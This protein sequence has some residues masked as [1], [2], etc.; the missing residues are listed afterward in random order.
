MPCKISSHCSER[1][2]V[3]VAGFYSENHKSLMMQKKQKNKMKY[4]ENTWC[5]F[6]LRWESLGDWTEEIEEIVKSYW[7]KYYICLTKGSKCKMEQNT[8][9]THVYICKFQT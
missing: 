8:F 9:M 2:G 1:V 6:V 7:L 4:A 5:K 3:I